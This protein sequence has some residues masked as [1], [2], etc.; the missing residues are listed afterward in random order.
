MKSIALSGYRSFE[1]VDRPKPEASPKRIV[2]KTK[3]VAICG[4]DNMFWS[5]EDYKGHVPGHEFSGYIEDPGEFPLKKGA[6]VCAAEFNPCGQCEFCKSGREQLCPQMMLDNP[7][8]S[9]DGGFGE[10]LTVRGDFVHELPDDV[11]MELGAIVEPVAVSL[12]GVNYCD[13][14]PG[15]SV[16]IWG[17]GPIGIYAAACAKLKGAEKVY[18]VGRNKGRVDFCN[19]FDFVDQCFS[20]KDED[21]LQQ[22]EAVKPQGGFP[23]VMDCLGLDNYDQLA[24]LAKPGTTIVIL[25]MHAPQLSVN[26][27]SLY[28]KE[29]SIRTGLYFSADD[30]TEAFHLICANKELFLKTI[31]AV[32]P[33]E[34]QAVQDA[35]TKL[36]ASGN[37]NEC[38]IVIKYDD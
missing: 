22:L 33:H 4:S 23:N 32:V 16:L 25:G 24:S 6:R 34:V 12:H 31:T 36:F 3:Y 7:G 26:A 28:L 13:I 17:N 1:M 5:S 20:V 19:S 18:M 10:Y 27:M 8:V 11:P 29:L 35:F 30:Y 21:F 15:E 38:K 14:Q 2:L 37:N 9:M